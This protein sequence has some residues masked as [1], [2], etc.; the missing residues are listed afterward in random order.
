MIK[1][2]HLCE[3]EKILYLLSLGFP[4]ETN[5]SL[6]DE[7]GEIQ[8]PK[9]FCVHLCCEYGFFDILQELV[10]RGCYLESKDSYQRTPLMVACEVG[11]FNIVQ[12][13]IEDCKVSLTGY[14]YAGHNIIHISAINGNLEVLR[15]LIEHIGI[16]SRLLTTYKKTALEICRDFYA[17]DFNSGLEKVISY[18]R[19]KNSQRMILS[20]PEEKICINEI[21]LNCHE[22][23]KDRYSQSLDTQKLQN[24]IK[25]N[26]YREYDNYLYR[27]SPVYTIK[28]KKK[29]LSPFNLSLDKLVNLKC[30]KIYNKI[31]HSEPANIPKR[32]V[33][34]KAICGNT[35]VGTASS[36]VIPQ[37]LVKNKINSAE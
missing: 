17:I 5:L 37:A 27:K 35:L 14:N 1:A 23:C 16:N 24:N 18:L 19:A 8:I 10:R 6:R 12:Y 22:N 11:E 36:S 15:Y 4:T 20:F 13:L 7:H 33:L 2:F 29:A 3:K 25:F 21:L 34:H 28:S 31:I 9:T 30:E 32:R 26:H